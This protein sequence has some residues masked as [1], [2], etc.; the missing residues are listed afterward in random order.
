MMS[1]Y[2]DH[3]FTYSPKLNDLWDAFTE[4]EGRASIQ[5]SSTDWYVDRIKVDGT[6]MGSDGRREYLM[7]ELEKDHW[8]YAEIEAWLHDTQSDAIQDLVDE[9]RNDFRWRAA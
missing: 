9:A 1:A 5:C 4:F 8:L 2:I 6:R 3:D 7:V